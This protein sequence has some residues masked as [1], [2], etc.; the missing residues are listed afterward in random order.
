ML[1][2]L[3][4][5]FD[6]AVPSDWMARNHAL[7]EQRPLASLV[8][9][10]SHDAASYSLG[11]SSSVCPAR[12][13]PLAN[14]ASFLAAPRARTQEV[15][16]TAQLEAGVRYL[17]LRVCAVPGPSRFFVHHTFLGASL[18]E[19]L[20]QIDGFSRAHPREVLLLDFQHLTGFDAQDRKEL[21]AR[22]ERRFAGR[23]LARSVAP[24]TKTLLDLWKGGTS[25]VVLME[26]A[27]QAPHVFDRAAAL[28][29][30][31]PNV[32]SVPAL[33]AALQWTA[34]D[35][36]RLHV[37]QWQLTPRLPDFLLHPL[38]SL[39][40]FA[41]GTNRLIEDGTLGHLVP[42]ARLNVVMTDDAAQVAAA[43]ARLNER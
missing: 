27:P 14:L 15:S 17:D 9:P 6:F 42:A 32:R 31:W 33:V 21:A 16:I 1:L 28:V 20:E 41:V 26:R 30:R 11:R 18:D 10:G 37:L 12:A 8:L 40:D 25:L 22:L 4:L 34:L 29:S 39:V 13:H 2:A 7:L 36:T 43:I 3:L 35:E 5:A 19:V 23:M 24:G 38:S